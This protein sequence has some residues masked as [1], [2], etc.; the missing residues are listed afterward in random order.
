[1]LPP[2]IPLIFIQKMSIFVPLIAAGSQDLSGKKTAER[3]L[4][5]GLDRRRRQRWKNKNEGSPSKFTPKSSTQR[6]LNE[7]SEEASKI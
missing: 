2:N 6:H 4:L 7:V 5:G 3:V 1:M